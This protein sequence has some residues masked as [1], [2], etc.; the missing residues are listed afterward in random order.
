M[1]LGY[2]L[3]VYITVWYWHIDKQMDRWNIGEDPKT[4]PTIC[5]NLVSGKGDML[6]D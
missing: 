2:D 1:R 3:P 6:D 5:E 4:D